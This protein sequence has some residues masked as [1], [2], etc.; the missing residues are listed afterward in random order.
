MCWDLKEHPF[1]IIIIKN[2]KG[3]ISVEFPESVNLEK[4]Y[5]IH[6][7][8]GE[9][10]MSRGFLDFDKHPLEVVATLNAVSHV[11]QSLT[12]LKRGQAHK[13]NYASA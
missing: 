8:K 11:S 2:H 6:C 3:K 5:F 7:Q 9:W 4:L 10:Y 1:I 13:K 12:E